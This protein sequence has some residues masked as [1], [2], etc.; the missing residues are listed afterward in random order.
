IGGI[1]YKCFPNGGIP[2]PDSPPKQFCIY[3][4]VVWRTVFQYSGFAGEDILSKD[5]SSFPSQKGLLSDPVRIQN[6]IGFRGNRSPLSVFYQKSCRQ[7]LI[8][9]RAQKRSSPVR[10]KIG[11]QFGNATGHPGHSVGSD[12]DPALVIP[13]PSSGIY[14]SKRLPL[15]DDE[16]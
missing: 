1:I 2:A 15:F 14:I 3:G 7:P 10:A 16:I 13:Q 9:E 11:H 4:N 12:Q 5:Q 8:I 6:G